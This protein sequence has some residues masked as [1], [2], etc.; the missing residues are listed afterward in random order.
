MTKLSSSLFLIAALA[1]TALAAPPAPPL[2]AY[3]PGLT[4]VPVTNAVNAPFGFF[5]VALVYS[6][7]TVFKP[8]TATMFQWVGNTESDLGGYSVYFGDIVSSNALA[9]LT[10]PKPVNAVVF[11]GLNTNVVYGF[12]TTAFNTALQE[13]QPSTLVVLKPGTP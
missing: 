11:L 8:A 13:S 10:V 5:P 6:P 12:Y 3:V 1:I 4:T 7:T 2:G 9:K